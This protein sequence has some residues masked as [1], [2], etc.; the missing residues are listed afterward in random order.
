MAEGMHC[1]ECSP[2]PGHQAFAR[3]DPDLL[4]NGRP[5]QRQPQLHLINNRCFYLGCLGQLLEQDPVLLQQP[6]RLALPA[7]PLALPLALSLVLEVEH[8][9]GPH[10]EDPGMCLLMAGDIG[11]PPK[12]PGNKGEASSVK[13]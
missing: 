6:P 2:Q 9:K 5:P 7:P 13:T 4:P 8:G 3:H 12:D 1:R 11:P 10:P